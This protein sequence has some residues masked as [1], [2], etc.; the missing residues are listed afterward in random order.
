MHFGRRCNQ[1]PY[2]VTEC[3]HFVFGQ[4]IPLSQRRDMLIEFL[5]GAYDWNDQIQHAKSE[6]VVPDLP[7]PVSDG[8]TNVEKN[9]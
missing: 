1:F 5:H 4:C 3:F 8:G 7:G 2:L 6:D 9:A